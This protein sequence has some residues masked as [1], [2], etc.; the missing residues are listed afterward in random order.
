MLDQQGD[1]ACMRRRRVH[2]DELES[3]EAESS[4]ASTQAASSPETARHL[5]NLGFN[6][7]L[8]PRWEVM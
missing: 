2:H 3:T 8:P 5:G 1:S 4:P 6:Q 7:S